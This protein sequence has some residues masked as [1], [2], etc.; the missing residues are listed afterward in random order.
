[1]QSVSTATD[2]PG[3]VPE[4]P[5]GKHVTR[6]LKSEVPSQYLTIYSS[7]VYSAC[8]NHSVLQCIGFLCLYSYIAINPV[9]SRTDCVR[10]LQQAAFTK[11]FR[12]TADT[13]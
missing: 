2:V 9:M 11:T 5:S 12:V 8:H 3:G 7:T 1:M 4:L 10:Q 13:T 6:R